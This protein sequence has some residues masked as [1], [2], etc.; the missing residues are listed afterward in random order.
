MVSPKV[1]RNLAVRM[2]V[3]VLFAVVLIAAVAQRW[4]GGCARRYGLV[5][6]AAIGGRVLYIVLA[7][8]GCRYH[9]VR[10]ACIVAAINRFVR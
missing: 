1:N 5:G 4:R 10:I 8:F 6:V 9:V 7:Q 2:R 3:F